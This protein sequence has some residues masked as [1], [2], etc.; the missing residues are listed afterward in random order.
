MFAIQGKGITVTKDWENPFFENKQTGKKAKYVTLDNLLSKINPIS[1]EYKLLILHYCE[2]SYLI[3][4]IIDTETNSEKKEEIQSSFLLTQVD[5][6]KQGAAITYAKR[7][8]L[9]ALFNV[10]TDKDDDANKASKVGE[11]EENAEKRIFDAKKLSFFKW[12]NFG[13]PKA[14]IMQNMLQSTK[15]HTIP[16]DIQMEID[17]FLNNLS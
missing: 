10:T 14:E 17:L 15:D 13:K 3:T 7:Y 12:K 2:N 11:K 6:Q 16:A 8:N 9:S 5:P 4:K 1:Q